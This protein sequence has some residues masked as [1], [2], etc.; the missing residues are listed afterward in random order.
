MNNS[1]TPFAHEGLDV[2]RVAL[3]LF[4]EIHEIAGEALAGHGDLLKQL[5]RCATS[6]VL[7]IGERANRGHHKDKAS[8]FIIARG[9]C[10]ECACALDLLHVSGLASAARVE[11]LK[12]TARRVAA[13]LTGLIRRERRLAE[14][15]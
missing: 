1:L 5:R 8:R 9:E 11:S 3:R 14:S 7:N 13:M 6:T 4:S 2:Y 12:N 15:G 10:G